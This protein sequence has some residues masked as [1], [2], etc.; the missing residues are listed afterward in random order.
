MRIQLIKVFSFYLAPSSVDIRIS[1][2][3]F[4]VSLISKFIIGAT[5]HEKLPRDFVK[6]VPTQFICFS[7]S[8]NRLSFQIYNLQLSRC[9]C[10]VVIQLYLP[11]WYSLHSTEIHFYL[12][13][14]FRSAVAVEVGTS[15]ITVLELRP[16]ERETF[17]VEG[18]LKS[19]LE[20]FCQLRQNL[21]QRLTT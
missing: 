16:R 18:N 8:H 12:F 11:T 2:R 6:F 5:L 14:I 21:D 7:S 19:S 15:G 1:F 9:R 3:P 20:I 17:E 13:C 4:L 10:I